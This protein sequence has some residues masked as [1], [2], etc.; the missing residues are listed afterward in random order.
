MSPVITISS[1]F[2]KPVLAQKNHQFAQIRFKES[3]TAGGWLAW[4]KNA[5]AVDVYGADRV[6]RDNRQ[7]IPWNCILQ[8]ELKMSEDEFLYPDDVDYELEYSEDSTSEPDVNME[9]QYYH[10]KAIKEDSPGDALGAFQK[11]VDLQGDCKGEWGFKALK[12]MVLKSH[13]IFGTNPDHWNCTK[14]TLGQNQDH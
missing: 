1:K 2:Y 3:T 5:R 4:R 6:V 10:S 13:P 8:R 9:N 11:V 7:I 14:I 12:Q